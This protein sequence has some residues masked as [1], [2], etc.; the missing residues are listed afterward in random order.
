MQRGSEV[1]FQ[2]SLLQNALKGIENPDPGTTPFQLAS[3]LMQATAGIPGAERYVG[4]LFKVLQGQLRGQN[5]GL[6][7]NLS[8]NGAASNTGSNGPG[9]ASGKEF[10][11]GGGYL[12]SPMTSDEANR[13]AS[14]FAMGDPANIPAGL[15]VANKIDQ[16]ALKNLDYFRE[17]AGELGVTKEELP[18]FVQMGQDSSEKNPEKLLVDTK[19]DLDQIRSLDR[20]LVPGPIRGALQKTPHFLASMLGGKETREQ[21][22]RRLRGPVDSLVKDG[23]EPIVRSKLSAQGLSLTEVEDLIHPMSN[24]LES[25]I[26][27]LP[28]SKSSASSPEKRIDMLADFYKKNVKPDTS[29][30]VLRHKLW[31]DKNYSWQE[32]AQAIDKAQRNGLELE[33]SQKTELTEFTSKPPGES[34]LDI[35]RDWDQIGKFITGKK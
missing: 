21:A 20:A 2:R 25:K 1:G 11:G 13:V 12:S 34:L 29:L 18:Y 22:I 8:G 5:T 27:S 7:D 9:N 35:F 28:A 17:R 10:Q 33:G 4:E 3:S 31:K 26:S 15:D 16:R 23:H 14:K 19:R 32:Q 24:D 6:L 30:L